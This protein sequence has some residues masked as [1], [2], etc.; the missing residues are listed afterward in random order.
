M[1]QKLLSIGDV[2]RLKGVNIQSLRYYDRIGIL[3]PAYVNPDTGY[4]YYVPEQIIILDIIQLC[5]AFHLPLKSLEA[6]QPDSDAPLNLKEMILN[7]QDEARKKLAEAQKTLDLSADLINQI[8]RLDTPHKTNQPYQETFPVR[9]IL[10]LPWDPALDTSKTYL[11]LIAD[12][13]EQARSFGL[14]ALSGQ[15]IFIT[16]P[17]GVPSPFVYLAVKPLAKNGEGTAAAPDTYQELPSGTYTCMITPEHE[18]AH[19]Q[20]VLDAASLHPSRVLCLNT[21]I[22]DYC[23]THNIHQSELQMI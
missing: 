11:K 23:L 5:L 4:R 22:Y 15:G 13:H 9:A 21:D 3:K 18:L 7:G 10:T 12:L 17:L 16:D 20:N 2:A 14:T 8:E 19:I 6:L 1:K